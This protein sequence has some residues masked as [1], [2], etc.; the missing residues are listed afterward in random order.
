[1]GQTTRG[2]G[3]AQFHIL[4]SISQ[5]EHWIGYRIIG[6]GW[7]DEVSGRVLTYKLEIY[8]MVHFWWEERFERSHKGPA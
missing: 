6:L 1:M 5:E 4:C 7:P 8:F 3:T 2:R